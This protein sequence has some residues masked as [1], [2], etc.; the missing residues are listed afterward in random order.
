MGFNYT[1]PDCNAPD[2]EDTTTL[3]VIPVVKYRT[4]DFKVHVAQVNNDPSALYNIEVIC[5]K[6][7]LCA[8]EEYTGGHLYSMQVLGSMNITVEE[9]NQ[10]QVSDPNLYENLMAQYYYI[11]KK[12]TESGEIKEEF[13]YKP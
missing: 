10:V 9:L 1:F 3:D 13:F 2:P 8:Q 6:N 7:K 12:M 5:T 4:T 11:L